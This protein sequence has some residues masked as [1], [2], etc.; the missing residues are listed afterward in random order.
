MWNRG[1]QR[2]RELN[3]KHKINLVKSQALEKFTKLY[4][5]SIVIIYICNYYIIL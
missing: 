3:R 1:C 2:Y 5:D 4:S